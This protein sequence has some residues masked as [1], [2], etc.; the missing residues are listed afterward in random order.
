MLEA[1][2]AGRVFPRGTAIATFERGRFPA[3]CSANYESTRLSC[4]HAALLLRVDEGGIWVM[5]QCKGDQGRQFISR[6]RIGIPPPGK[7]KFQDGSYRNAGNNALA[8]FVIER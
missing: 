2:T 5:D 8:Y 3:K 4:K 6:R 1:R 7:Q